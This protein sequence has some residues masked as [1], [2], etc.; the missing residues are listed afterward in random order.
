[1]AKSPGPPP[2]NDVWADIIWELGKLELVNHLVSERSRK[3][4]EQIRNMNESTRK[5]LLSYL[6]REGHGG[7]ATLEGFEGVLGLDRPVKPAAA[8][9]DGR[10]KEKG[11]RTPLPLKGP[12]TPYMVDQLKTFKKFLGG[13]TG[14]QGDK[15]KLGA[16]AVQCWR[17]NRSK[18]NKARYADDV[19]HGYTTEKALADAYRKLTDRQ[20]SQL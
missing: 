7:E 14:Y 11:K 13:R 2:W 8:R 10:K 3:V 20:L 4:K 9:D 12:R 15:S 19:M 1:M 16:W 6:W 18:W 17:E 5:S